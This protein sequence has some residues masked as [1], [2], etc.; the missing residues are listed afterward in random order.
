MELLM[1][2]TSKFSTQIDM[3]M[4]KVVYFVFTCHR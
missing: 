4:S 1:N 2:Y 3:D